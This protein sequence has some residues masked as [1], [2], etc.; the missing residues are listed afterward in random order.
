MPT[1]PPKL[2]DLCPLVEDRSS[3]E[4]NSHTR[5]MHSTAN[6]VGSKASRR[7]HSS[8]STCSTLASCCNRG[9]RNLWTHGQSGSLEAAS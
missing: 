4:G 3:Q 9:S 8:N 2:Q 6:K 5:H 1:F 7:S